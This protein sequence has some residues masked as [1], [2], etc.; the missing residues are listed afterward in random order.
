MSEPIENMVVPGDEEHS[1]LTTKSIAAVAIR[2]KMPGITILIHGVNDVG[3]AFAA[4]EQG[5]CKGLNERLRRQDIVAADYEMP[6]KPKD[7]SKFKATDV[8]PDPDKVY[9]QRKP[10]LGF[11]PIIPF[12]WGFREE[13]A[14]ANDKERHGQ[15]LDRFGNRL[16]KRYGKNG[17]PFA[18]ATTT[19]PDMFGPGFRRNLLVKATPNSPTHPLLDAPPRAYMVLAAQRLASLL[20]IIRKKSPN[21]PINIVA[22]SQGG[23]VTLLAHAMLAQDAKGPPIKADTIILN[24]TPYSLEEPGIE[25]F[26]LGGAQQTKSARINTLQKIIVDYITKSPA[27]EPKFAEL[28]TQSDVIGPTWEPAA[29]MERDNRGKVYLY[30]SPD[31]ITVGLPNI[32]GMGCWGI[33][34]EHLPNLGKRFFQRMFASPL[35]LNKD[36]SMV[37]NALKKV[38]VEFKTD[39]TPTSD[40][41]L[42]IN[43]EPLAATFTP[44]LGPKALQNGPIDASIAEANPYNKKGLEGIRPD[45]TPEDAQA[46]WLNMMDANSYHSSIVSNSMHSQKAT[47]YD[48]CIG[49]SAILKDGDLKWIQFLRAAADWRTNWLGSAMGDDKKNPSFPAVPQEIVDMLEVIDSA[50]KEIILGNNSYYSINSKSAGTLPEFTKKCTV[51]SLSPY[52]ISETVGERNIE[53]AKRNEMYR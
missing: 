43:G 52:I 42:T 15:Y 13:T 28:K 47:A 50:E 34:D 3:E 29:N 21:E 48:L 4:Q 22:H 44:E 19:I 20:R 12:Y 27:T 36:S 16:D 6:P 33:D 2:N 9:Y 30:F 53:D 10:E 24:N 46:R 25:G 49:A 41:K 7:G 45:E 51:K 39:V 38:K 18:N 8:N 14:L 40:R 5:I 31:D 35:G 26:M 23:F 17:G 1:T 11:S 37:G 32:Q